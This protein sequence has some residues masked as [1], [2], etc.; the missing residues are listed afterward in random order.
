MLP[1][2]IPRRSFFIGISNRRQTMI[3]PLLAFA[4]CG[5][6][7]PGLGSVRGSMRGASGAYARANSLS[8]AGFEQKAPI[9]LDD[10]VSLLVRGPESLLAQVPGSVREHGEGLKGVVYDLAGERLEVVAEG[11]KPELDQLV[12]SINASVSAVSGASCRTAWQEPVGGYDAQFPLVRAPSS[13]AHL[14]RTRQPRLPQRPR[15]LLAT[16]HYLAPH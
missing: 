5:L 13:R 11:S 2:Q 10:R 15:R 1:V 14:S 3:A 8:M 7:V 4:A 16:P 12:S 6:V 9:S